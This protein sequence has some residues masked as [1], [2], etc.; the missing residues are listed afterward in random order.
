MLDDGRGLEQR[1]AGADAG[2]TL[3]DNDSLG[4]RMIRG[5]SLK[6]FMIPLSILLVAT[7]EEDL[8]GGEKKLLLNNELIFRFLDFKRRYKCN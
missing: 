7:F 8:F 3:T 1:R 4:S 2:D 5:G 6:N